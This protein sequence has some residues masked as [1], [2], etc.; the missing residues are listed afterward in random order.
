MVGQN[1]HQKIKNSGVCS[2][3]LLI[4][5]TDKEVDVLIGF[6]Y[7]I[8]NN[9]NNKS[10]IGKT[11]K[12]SIEERFRQHILDSKKERCK[13]RPLYRAFN[14]YGVDNFSIEKIGEYCED[15]LGSMEIEFIK[16][17][18]TYKNGYNATLGGDGK[19]YLDIVDIEVI[20]KYMELKTLNKTASYFKCDKGTIKNILLLNNID[21]NKNDDYQKKPILMISEIDELTFDGITDAANWIINNNI[22]KT[23]NIRHIIKGISRV[24]NNNDKY[25]SYMNMKWMFI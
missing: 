20:N 2:H 3:N 11:H 16:K 9:I 17:Y 12:C 7:K 13:D 23:K 5:L 10:Y 22:S 1:L 25:K 4:K 8:T 6:I 18:N 19:R 21:I 15:V 24:L 14:K